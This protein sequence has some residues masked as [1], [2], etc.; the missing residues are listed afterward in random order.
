M[1]S[2][3]L[4]KRF[5][6]VGTPRSDQNADFSKAV[7]A[8]LTARIKHIPARFLYDDKGSDLFE[9]ITKLPE[10]YLTRAE[11]EILTANADAIAASVGGDPLLVEFGSGSSTKTRLLIEALIQ[12]HNRL[13]YA[14]IDIS[15]VALEDSA[16]ELL[17]TYKSLDIV[18]VWGEYERGL[19][20]IE[21][22]ATGPRLVLWL[23]SNI[24]N[25]TEDEARDFLSEIRSRMTPADRLLVGADLVKDATVLKA[26]YDDAQGVTA[27]FTLN[28]IE[29]I[30]RELKGDLEVADFKYHTRWNATRARIESHLEVLRDHTA[31]IGALN[32]SVSFHKGELIH[33]EYSHKY[34][35][36]SFAKLASSVGL[37]E[38]KSWTDSQAR[39]LSV[40]LG[41]VSKET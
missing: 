30:R 8:G 27:A 3:K 15:R 14:P 9:R 31:H 26:A 18:G 2:L 1:G 41:P 6:L 40:L 20:E 21:R 25:L 37:V 5:E 32:L 13:S 29:R 24:G 28:L 11:H 23:G 17:N 4:S 34:T 12:R 10:Y 16:V 38:K 36:K 22:M 35:R 7:R 19:F 33:T 39:F